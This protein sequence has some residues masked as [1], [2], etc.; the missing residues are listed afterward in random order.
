MLI[1][2]LCLQILFVGD[3]CETLKMNFVI[4]YV[5]R[6]RDYGSN[7]SPAVLHRTTYNFTNG[8]YTNSKGLVGWGN[9]QYYHH[10]QLTMIYIPFLPLYTNFPK[11]SG[12]KSLKALLLTKAD[13]QNWTFSSVSE[14]KPPQQ[15][16]LR[17]K[18]KAEQKSSETEYR[19]RKK[20]RRRK[21]E[22][23]VRNSREFHRTHKRLVKPV[24]HTN[25]LLL[26]E[27]QPLGWNVPLESLK[28]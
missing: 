7:V 11:T 14:S 13:C 2:R 15:F 9:N 4:I 12:L 18:K 23:E 3:F 16:W 26:K 21:K 1:I 25:E 27:R 19:K 8:P 28:H 17:M 22:E 24:M 5:L 20:K 6:T 10:R